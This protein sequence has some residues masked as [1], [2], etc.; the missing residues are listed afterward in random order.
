[1]VSFHFSVLQYLTD[2]CSLVKTHL[3]FESGQT[4]LK[5]FYIQHLLNI[6]YLYITTYF[7]IQFKH[8]MTPFY[9]LNCSETGNVLTVVGQC[10]VGFGIFFFFSYS[11]D[12][13]VLTSITVW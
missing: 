10:L 9:K 1:M 4:A 11:S 6:T 2:R 3:M 8:N 12:R 7:I 5:F 13:F